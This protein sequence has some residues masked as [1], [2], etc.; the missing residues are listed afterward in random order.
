[1]VEWLVSLS[2]WF[3]NRSRLFFRQRDAVPF[4]HV[5]F[6]PTPTSFTSVPFHS[7]SRSTPVVSHSARLSCVPSHSFH[8]TRLFFVPS[9]SVVIRPVPAPL[10][11]FVPFNPTTF[12]SHILFPRI[13]TFRSSVIPFRPVPSITS[14]PPFAHAPMCIPVIPLLIACRSRAM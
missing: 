12:R 4:H 6:H 11:R 3:V 10:L 9:H 7:M 5:P 13:L 8:P 2:G 14:S 1:M